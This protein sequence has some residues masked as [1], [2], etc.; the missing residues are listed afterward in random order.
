MQTT[1]KSHTLKVERCI[2]EINNSVKAERKKLGINKEVKPS[3]S[4]IE[5]TCQKYQLNKE[6]VKP[7]PRESMTTNKMFN[8]IHNFNLE[9]RC[10][11][12]MLETD[13][14]KLEESNL[15]CEY[16]VSARD[17]LVEFLESTRPIEEQLEILNK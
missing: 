5:T 13:I 7:K 6:S 10:Q 14:K 8:H 16:E 12:D 17:M 15:D 1:N 9:A 2:T 4:L 3:D 11:I